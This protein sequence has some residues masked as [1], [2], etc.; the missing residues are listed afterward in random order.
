MLAGASA[1]VYAQQPQTP[2][3]GYVGRT[4]PKEGLAPKVKVTEFAKA[5]RQFEIVFSKGD[6]VISGLTDFAA[7]YHV[8]T[9][10]FTAIGAV[11]K[12]TL[13]WSD[14]V[15]HFYKKNEINSEVEIIAFT[16]NIVTTNGKPYVH[17]H[18]VVGLP[19]GTTRGGHV[20]DA[21]ISLTMQ[22]FLEELEPLNTS[23]SAKSDQ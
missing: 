13:G 8:G 16:G 2:P 5:G 6:E 7:K 21:T 4:T 19:D 10:H 22:L 20:V 17:A 9:S 18:M 3:E 11:D 23:A 15:S 14:P 12:A 1:L